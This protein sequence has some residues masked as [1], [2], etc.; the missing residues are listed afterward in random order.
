MGQRE[1]RI[2]VSQG[3]IFLG[4]RMR[5]ASTLTAN[6]PT[7]VREEPAVHQGVRLV[8]APRGDHCNLACMQR[9][10]APRTGLWST[11]EGAE[12]RHVASS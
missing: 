9:L 8:S 1:L 6:V 4:T 11:R 7:H 2:Y 12:T 3:V 10:R 5:E